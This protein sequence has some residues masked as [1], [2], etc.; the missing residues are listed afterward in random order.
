MKTSTDNISLVLESMVRNIRLGR[1][2]Q[3]G[4]VDDGDCPIVPSSTLAFM[5]RRGV[6]TVYRLASGIIEVSK[7]NGVVFSQVSAPEITIDRLNFYVDGTGVNRQPRVFILVG[8][9]V[10][11]VAGKDRTKSRFDI[12]TLVSQRYI[13]VP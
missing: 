7:D 10:N 6:L 13:D 8:G 9:V 2:Y 3:C 11:G 1:N 12:E 4:G 5:D